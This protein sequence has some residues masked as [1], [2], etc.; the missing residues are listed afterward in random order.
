MSG[1][2]GHD[3]R[4]AHYVHGRV[5]GTIDKEQPRRDHLSRVTRVPACEFRQRP[6]QHD[7]AAT[8]Q[9]H[10]DQDEAGGEGVYLA[11][12]TQLLDRRRHR[13]CVAAASSEHLVM[14]QH[15]S[16][17]PYAPSHFIIYSSMTSLSTQIMVC[18]IN[19]YH[20]FALQ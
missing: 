12:E 10:A 9:L 14:T 18:L 3:D 2:G 8:D 4:V 1:E 13:S 20:W 19:E 6:Y 7:A 16:I 17:R 15:R 5:D 11:Q